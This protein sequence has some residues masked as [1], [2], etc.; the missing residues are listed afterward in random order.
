MLGECSTKFPSA[1][2]SLVLP[3]LREFAMDEPGNLQHF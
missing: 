1:M 2:L 3:C